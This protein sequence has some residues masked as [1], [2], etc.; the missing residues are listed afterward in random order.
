MLLILKAEKIFIIINILVRYFG[1]NQKNFGTI[2]MCTTNSKSL[3][4]ESSSSGD[5][6]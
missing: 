6:H 3:R 4:R 5:R 2:A 1:L